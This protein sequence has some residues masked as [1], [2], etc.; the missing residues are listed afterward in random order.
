[1][2]EIWEDI[3]NYEGYYQ[4]ST[5][6][7]IK[8]LDRYVK[9]NTIDGCRFIRGTILK[10]ATKITNANYKRKEVSLCKN[11]KCKSIF[12][13]RLVLKTF[14]SNPL[15]KRCVNHKDSNP[16]NNVLSNLE[17]VT[18]KENTQHA[19][20]NGRYNRKYKNRSDKDDQKIIKDYNSGFLM[21]EVA[22]INGLTTSMVQ[23]ILIRNNIPRRDKYEQ[24]NKYNIDRKG[25]RKAYDDNMTRMELAKKFNISRTR[26]SIEINNYKKKLSFKNKE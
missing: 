2:K 12:V 16:C 22:K 5:L 1:V 21:R 7:R 10:Q 24:R 4:A 3:P 26:V 11:G 20:N 25:I 6:G 8:S 9:G 23:Y 14:I 17:W 13:H 15:K 19:I 18:H